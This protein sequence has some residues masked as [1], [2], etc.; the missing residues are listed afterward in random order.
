M[1]LTFN[2]LKVKYLNHHECHAASA[3]FTSP[4]KSSDILTID[5]HGELD[6]CFLGVGKNNNVIQKGRYY[7]IMDKKGHSLFAFTIRVYVFLKP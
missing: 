3:F 6:T 2:N 7:K 4:F 5:G 1:T